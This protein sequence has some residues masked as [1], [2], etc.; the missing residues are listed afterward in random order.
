[1]TRRLSAVISA[2]FL[3]VAASAQ[4]KSEA[5]TQQYNDDQASSK[6]S[7][8][9]MFSFKEYFGALGHKNEMKIGT[10]FAGAC[11]FVGGQQIYNKDYWK[12]PIVYGSILGAA[13]T[14]VWFNTHG[15]QD[16]SKWCFIGAGVAYWASLLDGVVCYKPDDYPKPGKATI[17][18]ILLP[19]LGQIYNG[20][21]WKL[22]IYLGGMTAAVHFYHDNKV[23]Y[24]RFRDIYNAAN[25]P[26]IKYDGPI[27]SE[28]A[29]YYRDVYRRYRDYS[30]LAIGAIYLLQIIDANVFSYM[31]D[32]EVTD[33]L[34]ISVNPTLIMPESPQYALTA[35]SAVGVRLGFTF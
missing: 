32:F 17:Y 19:G 25:N 20:E 9:V 28:T 12:L 11:V 14:G 29:L 26:D 1:M 7:V 27:T 33:D 6:D 8:D 5:F 35:P 18:S 30:L 21:V 13:G 31:H 24:V 2:L 4:F 23:N 3:C 34:A 10:S 15:R 22:P 16:I